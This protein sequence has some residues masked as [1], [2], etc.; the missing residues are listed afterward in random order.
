MDAMVSV[1][2]KNIRR[3]ASLS[4]ADN[5][6]ILQDWKH[7]A[8]N[9]PRMSTHVAGTNQPP[10]GTKPRAQGHPASGLDGQAR[11]NVILRLS[12]Q[13]RVFTPDT[14]VETRRFGMMFAKWRRSMKCVFEFAFA[15]SGAR[16]MTRI[17]SMC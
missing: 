11:L 1:P 9:S 3:G 7:M 5:A 15:S 13:M 4:R 14:N 6:S 10:A 8:Q 17:V 12:I 16:G 2:R